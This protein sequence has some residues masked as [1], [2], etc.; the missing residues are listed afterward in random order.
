M[1]GTVA[2]QSTTPNFSA[3]RLP[4]ARSATVAYAASAPSGTAKRSPCRGDSIASSTIGALASACAPV[5]DTRSTIAHHTT[6]AC[7]P[8][9]VTAPGARARLLDTTTVRAGGVV[10]EETH[11][12]IAGHSGTARCPDTRH[13]HASAWRPAL[14]AMATRRVL[15][16]PPCGAQYA[17]TT[18]RHPRCPTPPPSACHQSSPPTRRR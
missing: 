13:T 6:A 17:V 18:D 15:S 2:R 1:H 9:G 5:A 16:E 10:P 12:S 14:R 3:A 11:S 4:D 8:R 7:A